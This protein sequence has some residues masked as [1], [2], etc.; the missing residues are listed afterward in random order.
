[1]ATAYARGILATQAR[2]TL[3]MQR[4]EQSIHFPFQAGRPN[5]ARRE[6]RE[7]RRKQRAVSTIHCIFTVSR[8]HVEKCR[9]VLELS[10][11]KSLRSRGCFEEARQL[12]SLHIYGAPWPRG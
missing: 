5:A 12:D 1:M 2:S 4:F 10:F 11:A 9:K 3:K 7:E 6:Q 8:D